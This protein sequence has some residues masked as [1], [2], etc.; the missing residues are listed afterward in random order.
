MSPKVALSP[1]PRKKQRNVPTLRW[2]ATISGA[3]KLS[4]S[5]S[6]LFLV[7]CCCWYWHGW[8][9]QLYIKKGAASSREAQYSLS[10]FST[11]SMFRGC[12][13]YS[14]HVCL[15]HS[16]LKKKHVKTYSSAFPRSLSLEERPAHGKHS[17]PPLS[18]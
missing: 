8:S 15:I 12:L 14:L 13:I 6:L 10:R 2:C 9:S 1:T 16:H 11:A 7:M 17:S 4:L 3:V 18:I 5:L